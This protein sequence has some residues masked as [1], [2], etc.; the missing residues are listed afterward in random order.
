MIIDFRYYIL[1]VLYLD[2]II[3]TI[4]RNAL[5]SFRLECQKS[6][7]SHVTFSELLLVQHMNYKVSIN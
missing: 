2:I 6:P 7:K 3:Q 4:I 1:Y 5:H